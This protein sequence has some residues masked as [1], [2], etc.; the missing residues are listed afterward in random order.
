MGTEDLSYKKPTFLLTV[1]LKRGDLTKS[2]TS[3]QQPIKNNI[4]FMPR[5][6]SI[7][8]IVAHKHYI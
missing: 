5:L 1:L 4:S 8:L 7:C 6:I 3:I 2:P